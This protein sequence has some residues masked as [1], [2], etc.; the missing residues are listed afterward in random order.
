MAT[1]PSEVVS[2]TLHE[3]DQLPAAFAWARRRALELVYDEKLL[4]LELG[5]EG[6]G[7]TPESPI[8][9]Y[10][11]VGDLDDFDVLPILWQY[12]DPRTG[13]PAGPAAYPAATSNS[14]FHPN[15]LVCAPWSRLAYA[16]FGGPHRDWGGL[17][18]WK[19]PRPP[20]THAITIPD[21]L[22]RLYRDTRRSRGRMA[23][24]PAAG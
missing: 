11:I 14:I 2:A 10:R 7:S 17:T 12:V 6:P 24:L 13:Q 21:M 5:L 22:D 23:S 18:D 20:Y 4:R 1:I 16:V 8:E 15:G 3:P 9:R 19:M